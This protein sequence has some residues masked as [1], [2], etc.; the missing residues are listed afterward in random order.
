[1]ADGRVIGHKNGPIGTLVF[2]NQAKRN[3]V[4]LAM[5]EQV[6]EILGD[7]TSDPDIRMIVVTGAGETTFVSGMDISEFETKR[8]TAEENAAYNATAMGMYRAIRSSEKP[9]VAAIRGYCMGGGMAIACACDLRVCSDDSQ[10][11]VPAARLGLVYA[12]AYTRWL[13]DVVG[14]AYAKEILLTAR[15][16]STAEAQRM[17]LVHAVWPVGEFETSCENYIAQIAENAPLSMMAAKRIIDDAA[18]AFDQTSSEKAAALI[19]ACSSSEDYREGRRAFAEKR[20]PK[21]NGR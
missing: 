15:R 3:A 14:L 11:C 20:K 8:A 18:T 19:A 10:F 12:G 4:S 16:Y 5:A 13:I 9:T 6:P 17:G 21:F 1:M 2:D 7:F